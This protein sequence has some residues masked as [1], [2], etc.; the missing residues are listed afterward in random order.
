MTAF[1]LALLAIATVIGLISMVKPRERTQ[2]EAW[3]EIQ[4]KGRKSKK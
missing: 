2:W 1:I 3:M 4:R